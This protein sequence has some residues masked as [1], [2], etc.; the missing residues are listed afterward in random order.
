[1]KYKPRNCLLKTIHHAKFHFD[2]TI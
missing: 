1:M 2:P